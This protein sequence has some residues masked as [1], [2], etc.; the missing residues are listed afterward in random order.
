MGFLFKRNGN[1]SARLERL[2]WEQEAA[3]SNPASHTNS[4]S[5]EIKEYVFLVGIPASGKT[6][7]SMANMPDNFVRFNR[8]DIREML[9]PNHNSKNKWYGHA[10]MCRREEFI[11]GMLDSLKGRFNHIW[12]DN[13]NLAWYWLR[14]AITGLLSQGWSVKVIFMGD[15]E[16]PSLCAQRDS[17]RQRQV[18]AQAI[19]KFYK[20]Y[21]NVKENINVFYGRIEILF[22]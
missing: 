4:R 6:T 10:E 17:E 22:I 11:S 15:S 2:L 9:V 13:T 12:D 19:E 8:D 21:I 14:E 18:G 1:S 5:M 20:K 16:F 7:Y 3:G